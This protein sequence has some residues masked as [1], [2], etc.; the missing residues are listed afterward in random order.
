MKKLLLTLGAIAALSAPATA[1]DLPTRTYTRAPAIIDPAYNWTGF[2][3][4]AGLGWQRDQTDW[5]TTEI[6]NRAGPGCLDSAPRK[7]SG[8][9]PGYAEGG[10]LRFCCG[11]G[12]A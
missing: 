8:F 3:L 4:G 6:G 11:V 5:E 9:L 10:A 12:R 2:Y 1:A 7:L